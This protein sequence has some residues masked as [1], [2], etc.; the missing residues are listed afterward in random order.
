M[1]K[2]NIHALVQINFMHF[3]QL[4]MYT[5]SIHDTPPNHMIDF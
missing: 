3:Q 2:D 5:C 4:H 1:L